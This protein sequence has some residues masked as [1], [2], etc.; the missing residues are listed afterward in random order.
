MKNNLLEFNGIDNIKDYSFRWSALDKICGEIDFSNKKLL[1]ATIYKE[2]LSY[3]I[4]NSFEEFNND[5]VEI[6][7]NILII[8]C[9]FNLSIEYCEES[10]YGKLN[11]LH[12]NFYKTIFTSLE[13]YEFSNI[14]N[15]ILI[16]DF[17]LTQHQDK[18]HYFLEVFI[19]INEL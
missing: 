16:Q 15:E 6:F 8:N 12:H 18:I 3:K 5:K 19:G 1:G 17:S 4:I 14:N 2:I 7:N 9:K 11:L 13:E 10:S